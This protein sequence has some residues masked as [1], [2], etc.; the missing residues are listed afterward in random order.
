MDKDPPFMTIEEVVPLQEVLLEYNGDNIDETL[1]NIKATNF[2][3][4]ITGIRSLVKEITELF[5]IR[6]K[7]SEI[8]A[9]LCVEII[10]ICP[11]FKTILLRKLFHAARRNDEKIANFKLALRLMKLDVFSIEELYAFITNFPK[12]YENQYFLLIITFCNEISNDD[13][14]KF[15][16]MLREVKLMNYLSPQSRDFFETVVEKF[17]HGRYASKV[18]KWA[19]LSQIAMDGY[20]EGTIEYIVKNDDIDEFEKKLAFKPFDLNMKVE[21]S[22]FECYDMAGKHPSLI[23]FAAM[24]GSDKIF[25]LLAKKKAYVRQKDD[26]G[27][28]ITQFTAAG[29]SKAAWDWCELHEEPFDNALIAAT[30]Y[31][32]NENFDRIVRKGAKHNLDIVLFTAA[33]SNNIYAL[34]YCIDN[35]ANYEYCENPD[36]QTPLHAAAG[37]GNT[38]IVK[39]LIDIPGIKLNARD[40]RGR[41]PLHLASENGHIDIVRML[42][43]TP[44]IRPNIKDEYGNT[45]LDLAKP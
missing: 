19:D 1:R 30:L 8:I 13:K 34:Q 33:E 45:A 4:G 36:Q 14:V 43:A 40:N 31:R 35:G 21:P 29:D 11:T 37:N 25:K 18:G 24:N 12:R 26:I 22:L 32:R 42:L 17:W 39:V 38:I 3:K 20:Q 9:K 7:R 44:G 16:K 15:E 2:L 28:T 5:M 10:K 6:P 23:S 41:T 27:R